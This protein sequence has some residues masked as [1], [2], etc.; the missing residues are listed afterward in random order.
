MATEWRGPF[1]DSVVDWQV[2]KTDACTVGV[3][4]SEL[5]NVV[6]GSCDKNMTCVSSLI[7]SLTVCVIRVSHH[8]HRYQIGSTDDQHQAFHH[9]HMVR[10]YVDISCDSKSQRHGRDSLVYYKW[11]GVGYPLSQTG[12]WWHHIVSGH[13]VLMLTPL[14]ICVCSYTDSLQLFS[15]FTSTTAESL[16]NHNEA[17]LQRRCRER[18]QEIDHMQQVLETKIQ[19]LQEVS[20]H[21]ALVEL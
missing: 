16:T 7:W 2:L 15:L 12:K 3:W 6:I 21:T 1:W 9:I 19:L 18:Q 17:E 10:I 13:H 20:R 8:K 5:C 4:R 14:C 11:A